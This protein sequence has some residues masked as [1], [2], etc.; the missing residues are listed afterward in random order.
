MKPR[1]IGNQGTQL[2]TRCVSP[3]AGP[4]TPETVFDDPAMRSRVEAQLVAVEE[5]RR[6]ASGTKEKREVHANIIRLKDEGEG[7]ILGSHSARTVDKRGQ[8]E[9]R[10]F[11][12]PAAGIWLPHFHTAV[13]QLT[14][15]PILC[16]FSG[17]HCLL[18]RFNEACI[19]VITQ[20]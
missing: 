18:V 5:A 11:S 20:E 16:A 6:L 9:L 10:V 2:L 3:C 15:R 7:T 13:M 1:W 14:G 8:I 19:G 12:E 4:W 17:S